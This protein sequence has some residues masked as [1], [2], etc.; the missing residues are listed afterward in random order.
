MHVRS[1]SQIARLFKVALISGP[2]VMALKPVTQASD[3]FEQFIDFQAKL[4]V[5][6]ID[7][8]TYRMPLGVVALFIQWDNLLGRN[9]LVGD[10]QKELQNPEFH[11]RQWLGK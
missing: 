3:T 9:R 2:D 8:I 5:D 7:V 6:F 11:R 1:C 10:V 4:P